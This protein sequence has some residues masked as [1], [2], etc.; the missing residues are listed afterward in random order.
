MLGG[1]GFFDP[2]SGLP[3]PPPLDPT[4]ST[5]LGAAPWEYSRR[6]REQTAGF[7]NFSY[8]ANNFEFSAGVRVD[9]WESNRC[10]ISTA[11][12]VNSPPF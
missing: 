12:V 1:F 3:V 4:E 7:A 5:V 8:R 9:R 10:V 11:G 2:T 6:E